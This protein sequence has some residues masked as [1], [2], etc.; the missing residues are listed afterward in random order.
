[1]VAVRIQMRTRARRDDVK[2]MS[3]FK[4]LLAEK[5]IREGRT[6]SVRQVARDTGVPLSTVFGLANNTMTQIPV[7]GIARLCEYFNTDLCQMLTLVDD[8]ANLESLM[9]AEA[10]NL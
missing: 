9:H 3:R 2:V 1:M 4:I 7:D 10:V 6:I 8:D 5:E